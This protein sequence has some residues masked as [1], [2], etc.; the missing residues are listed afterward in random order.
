M[1]HRTVRIKTLPV[2]AFI[3]ALALLLCSCSLFRNDEK[4][5]NE[6]ILGQAQSYLDQNLPQEGFVIDRAYYA[7]KSNCYR[8]EVSKPGSIDSSFS[9]DYNLDTYELENDGYE[10]HV[11]SGWNT[12][13]RLTKDYHEIVCNALGGMDGFMNARGEL[14]RYS[15]TEDLTKFFS[16]QGIV[17]KDLILDHAYH[18]E[19]IGRKYGYIEMTV[20]DDTLTAERALE[21]LLQ[22]HEELKRRNADYYVLALSMERPTTEGET[23][24]FEIYGITQED[25]LCEDPLARLQQM[26]Q[27]QEAQRRAVKAQWDKSS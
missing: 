18:M 13:E 6:N 21:R 15:E 22:I 10:G 1:R 3:C 26:W 17:L 8:V 16:P 27:E 5:I 19:E 23:E 9:L 20:R 14:C 4:I 25:L 2:L 24:S 12:Y 7:F 11:L